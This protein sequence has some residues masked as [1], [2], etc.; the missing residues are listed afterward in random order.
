MQTTNE[1]AAAKLNDLLRGELSAV[2]TYSLAIEHIREGNIAA[3]LQEAHNCHAE[4]AN[5]LSTRLRTLGAEPATSSG[6]WGAFAKIL[7][8][9]AQIFGDKAT[10]AMLEE[11]EDHGL[12]Q[13]KALSQDRDPDISP[14]VKDFLPRQQSTY[15]IMKDLKVSLM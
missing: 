6:I 10:I 12:A 13:Y 14:L 9:G 7:E 5:S 2:E 1:N 4:R 3:I 15:N 11:G 8:S